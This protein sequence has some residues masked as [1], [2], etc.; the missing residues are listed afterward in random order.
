MPWTFRPSYMTDGSGIEELFG[1]LVFSGSYVQGGDIGTFDFFTKSTA[2]YSF[3]R[4]TNGLR[5][6][7]PPIFADVVVQGL[8]ISVLIPGKSATDFKIAIF[9]TIAQTELAATVYPAQITSIPF[10]TLSVAYLR[11]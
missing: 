2:G 3:Y 8:Y 11:L 4:K 9:D 10:H 6:S 7:R 1:Q 5:S